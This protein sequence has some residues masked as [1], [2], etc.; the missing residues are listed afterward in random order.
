MNYNNGFTA[1]EKPHLYAADFRARARAALKGFWGISIAALLIVS[2]LGGS[3]GGFTFDFDFDIS[4]EDL[5]EITATLPENATFEDVSE[6]LGTLLKDELAANLTTAV[7][8]GM[9]FGLL[10]S[11]AFTLFIGSPMTVGY[12]KFQLN[13]LDGKVGEHPIK[14]L[15]DFFSARYLATVKLTLWNFLLVGLVPLVIA[16][17]G[18]IVMVLCISMGSGNM[19]LLGAFVCIAL[20]IVSAVAAIILEYSYAFAAAILAEN[21]DMSA[22]DAMR[23]SREMM[24]GN[25]WRLF[26]LDL[27]YLGWYILGALACGIGILW[28][29]PYHNVG[30]IAFYDEIANRPKP[31]QQNAPGEGGELDYFAQ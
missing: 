16:F 19:I 14:G 18:L 3:I 5:Q 9:V 1:S 4:E 15:F 29:I 20:G 27:S 26:C 6:A 10:T 22:R 23:S 17:A 28:A 13:L 8:V 30:R 2:I 31:A 7:L 21:P 12:Q 11:I 25:K 24:A